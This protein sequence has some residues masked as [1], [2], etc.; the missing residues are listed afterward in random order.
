MRIFTFSALIAFLLIGGCPQDNQTGDDATRPQ[1][2]FPWLAPDLYTVDSDGD[3]L[4]DGDE[5][6]LGTSPDDSDTDADG[7]SDDVEISLGTDPLAEDT[8]GDGL[9]DSTELEL[10][11]DPLAEDTDKDGLNDG[12]EVEIGTDPLS[13]DSDADGLSDARE[14]EL[15]TNPTHPDSD[16]DGLTDGLE[17][18]I[19]TDPTVSDTDNDGLSDGEEADWGTDPLNND[20]DNDGI[21]DGLEVTCGLD[22]LMFNETG[23]VSEV[24]SEHVIEVFVNDF[25]V[26]F[27]ESNTFNFWLWAEGDLIIIDRDPECPSVLTA[28]NISLLDTAVAIDYGPTIDSGLISDAAVDLSWIAVDGNAWYLNPYDVNDVYRWCFGDFV[29]VTHSPIDALTHMV[30]VMRGKSA[31][32]W[33]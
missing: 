20:T 32:L 5:Q 10:G 13:T 27:Q 31:L 18:E 7:M 25:D 28:L 16:A 3:G 24:Y 1:T 21:Y 23:M 4:S 9:S 2:T 33:P 22:P 30:N 6:D 26:W 15:N 8:D 11:T 17:I 14:I 19:G 12:E 29:L